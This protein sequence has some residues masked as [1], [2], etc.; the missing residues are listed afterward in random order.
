MSDNNNN[1]NN[2]KFDSVFSEKTPNHLKNSILKQAEI[3][4]A[5]NR[6]REALKKFAFVFGGLATAS[7]VGVSISQKFF[8]YNKTD[9]Q[10]AEWANLLSSEDG[11]SLAELSDEDMEMLEQLDQLEQ[12]DHITDDEFDYILKEDV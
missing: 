6:R 3:I 10:M 11:L 5:Q 12:F 9:A 2:N 7:V 8:K 4:L 1:N